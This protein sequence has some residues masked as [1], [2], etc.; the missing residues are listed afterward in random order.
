M[1]D[2]IDFTISIPIREQD[3]QTVI[4]AF[5]SL[6]PYNSPYIAQVLD[7][8]GNTIDNPI[9]PAMYVEDCLAYYVMD[10]TRN[11]LITSAEGQAVDAAR[12]SANQIT[13]D[14]KNWIDSL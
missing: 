10:I 13:Q 7:Y 3:A 6:K 1:P 14:L 8:A 2:Q 9:T 11:F 12:E 5:L 4:D